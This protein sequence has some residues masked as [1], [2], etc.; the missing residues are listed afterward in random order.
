M[1]PAH[2]D[3]SVDSPDPCCC[4]W[5]AA[6]VSHRPV[7]PGTAV[8]DAWPITSHGTAWAARVSNA[9]SQDPLLAVAW[10][11]GLGCSCEEEVSGAAA[12]APGAASEAGSTGTGPLV[13][14]CASG[15]MLLA[16][17]SATGRLVAEPAAAVGAVAAEGAGPWPCSSAQARSPNEMWM[18]VA[19]RRFTSTR[20]RCWNLAAAVGWPRRA[21]KPSCGKGE[22][23]RFRCRS[24]PRHLGLLGSNPTK[25]LYQSKIQVL[26]RFHTAWTNV[27]V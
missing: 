18:S 19:P 11:P 14:M 10:A 1:T 27:S 5:W 13:S 17:L 3:W 7:V 9:S 15:M 12:A 23:V 2:S 8:M 21:M 24:G 4:C 6:E 26:F 20:C 22:R 16:L 25:C